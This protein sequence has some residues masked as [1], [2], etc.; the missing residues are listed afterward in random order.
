[1][2]AFHDIKPGDMD[3]AAERLTQELTKLFEPV[4][5]RSLPSENVRE[6]WS[7]EWDSQQTCV[8]VV[9]EDGTNLSI[10]FNPGEPIRIEVYEE[11]AED[12]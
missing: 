4:L 5:A 9:M 11:E 8:R 10:R 7:V 3:A 6:V 2:S 1:M 12:D